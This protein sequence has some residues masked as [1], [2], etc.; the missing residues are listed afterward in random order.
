MVSFFG[1]QSCTL[2]LLL[3]VLIFASGGCGKKSLTESVPKSAHV[4]YENSDLQVAK[5]GEDRYGELA[6][7]Q[8]VLRA[9]EI[10]LGRFLS[11][12]VVEMMIERGM[13]VKFKLIKGLDVTI[14]PVVI[15]V[16]SSEFKNGDEV[17][18]SVSGYVVSN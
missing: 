8:I 10:P 7:Y 14:S 4:V 11:S 9:K 18:F 12:G 3:L 16:N 13:D 1:K 2:G 17:V 15:G 5:L 6:P